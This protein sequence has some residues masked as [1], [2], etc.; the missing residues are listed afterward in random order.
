MAINLVLEEDEVNVILAA[1]AQE[2]FIEV[3]DLITKI[4]QQGTAQL[5]AAAAETPVEAVAVAETPAE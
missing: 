1:V 2:P 4:Q 3:V 5:Q